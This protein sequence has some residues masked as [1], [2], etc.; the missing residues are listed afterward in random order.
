MLQYNVAPP[1]HAGASVKRANTYSRNLL[2]LSSSSPAFAVAFNDEGDDSKRAKATT[3]AASERRH[4]A[5]IEYVGRA[6]D[7]KSY[8]R[9]L[10]IT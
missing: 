4:H 5:N 7:A 10:F 2:A 6:D 3:T 8:R 1:P 9:A